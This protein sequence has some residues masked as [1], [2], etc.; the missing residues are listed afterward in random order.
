[1]S[2]PRRDALAI[3]ARR[4]SEDY[5]RIY[6]SVKAGAPVSEAA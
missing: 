3:L 1:M 4:Y 6:Q 5:Q 2:S